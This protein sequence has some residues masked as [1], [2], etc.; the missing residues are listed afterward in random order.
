MD[1]VTLK[2]HQL[3]S[4]LKEAIA[5]KDKGSIKRQIE[6]ASQI[7]WDEIGSHLFETFKDLKDEAQTQNLI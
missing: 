5:E 1:T 7:N 3:L 6:R 2:A 4:R